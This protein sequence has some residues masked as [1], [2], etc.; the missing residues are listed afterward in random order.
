MVN[1]A[2]ITKEEVSPPNEISLIEKAKTNPEAFSVLYNK[3]YEQ[4]FR[5][6]YQRCD[7]K[8][9]AYDL[10]SQVFLKALTN[11]KKYKHQ[12]FP[13]SSWLYR[14]AKSEVY[15][16]LKDHKKQRAI[17]IDSE[18]IKDMIREIESGSEEDKIPL[19][20]QAIA[21]LSDDDLNI[22]EMRYFESMSF[23]TIGEVLDITE[24]NAKV[25]VY[26]ILDKLKKS[27][28]HESKKN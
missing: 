5:F 18:K 11:L 22:I 28:S 7:E 12:G 6:C 21:E 13:F 27:I 14:I 23:K 16:F 4:I 24:N 15:Q 26:R 2:G 17:N 9:D 10:T 25:R 3:Y 1:T 19:L 8:E 20:I